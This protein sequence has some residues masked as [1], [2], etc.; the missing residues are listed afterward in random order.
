M[1]PSTKHKLKEHLLNGVEPYGKDLPS[2]CM[3]VL[4]G[5][6]LLFAC[7]WR[8]GERYENIFTSYVNKCRQFK[9]DIIVF[10]GYNEKS[11]KDSARSSRSKSVS[12]T[13]EISKKGHCNND[14]TTFLS[15]YSNKSG[16][17][18]DV[19]TT[20]VRTAL[21]PIKHGFQSQNVLVMAD[22]TD[23]LCLLIHHCQIYDWYE[24]EGPEI[25]I[26]NVTV[27]TG[28]RKLCYL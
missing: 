21:D 13:A 9:V 6:A 1:R 28:T 16:F 18:A 12:A 20:I 22:D 7:D 2:D 8:K 3:I 19:D 23:I 27:R 24:H 4:D 11:T 15:N 5:G 10:D 14:R 17:V 25:F 26:K